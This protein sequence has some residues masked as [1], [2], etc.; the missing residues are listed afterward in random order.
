MD[1]IRVVYHEEWPHGWWAESPDVDGCAAAGATFAE[2][3]Q[4]AE[5]GVR[6]ALDR[7]NVTVEHFVPAPS[8]SSTAV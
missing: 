4:L 6:F 8:V 5:E 3:R 2:T 7:T 1:R